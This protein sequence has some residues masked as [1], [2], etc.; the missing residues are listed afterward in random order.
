MWIRDFEENLIKSVGPAPFSAQY[1]IC[2]L[3]Q[4]D[5]G[6]DRKIDGRINPGWAG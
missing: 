2:R 3:V 6:T 5:G 1:L 4:T